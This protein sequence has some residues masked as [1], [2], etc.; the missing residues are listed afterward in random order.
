MK[1]T[2]LMLVAVV[3]VVG[4][5]SL[6]NLFI[7]SP[8]GS[9]SYSSYSAYALE[10]CSAIKPDKSLGFD[11]CIRQ[12]LNMCNAMYFSEPGI[13]SGWDYCYGA[14]RRVVFNNCE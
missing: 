2:A 12:G 8:S 7:D 9:Y 13:M 14:C 1:K 5:F 10:K 4:L 11:E 3:A 6:F